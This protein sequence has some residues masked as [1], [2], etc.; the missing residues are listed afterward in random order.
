[1]DDLAAWNE[2]SRREQ[3]LLIKLFGGG[4]VTRE[5][6]EETA[7]LRRLGLITDGGLSAAGLKLFTS[8][9]KAQR[10]ARRSALFA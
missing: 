8:A 9:F 4:S 7:N 1:V 6:M 5:G 3:R 2:L 10:D